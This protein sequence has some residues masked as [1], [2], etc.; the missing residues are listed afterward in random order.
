MN[1]ENYATLS[2]FREKMQHTRPPPPPFFQGSSSSTNDKGLF[3]P[4]PYCLYVCDLNTPW[5]VHL[6]CRRSEEVTALNWDEEGR[7]LAVGDAGGS[8]EIWQM[9]DQARTT[10]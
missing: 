8:A 7:R 6:L 9:Q 1:L 3:N 4:G 2:S 10:E 5:D